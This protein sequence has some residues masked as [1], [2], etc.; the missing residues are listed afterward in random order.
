[1]GE[2]QAGKGGVLWYV[3]GVQRAETVN[4]AAHGVDAQPVR[5]VIAGPLAALVSVVSREL[6]QEDADP[7]QDITWLGNQAFAHESVLAAAFS[8]GPVLPLR[9]GAVYE[10]EEAVRRFLGDHS[11]DCCTSSPGWTDTA[12][13]A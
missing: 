6:F 11:H 7:P 4:R 13:G 2:S 3:Y 10:S 12:N 5:T 1:M 9:F 8:A